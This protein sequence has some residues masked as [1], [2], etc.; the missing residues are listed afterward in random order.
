MILLDLHMPIMNGYEAAERIREI[1]KDIPIVAMTADV[2][3]GVREKCEQYGIYHYIS[4]P[5]NPERFIQIIWGILKNSG[6]LT[7]NLLH[8][9]QPQDLSK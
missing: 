6:T 7:R 4:K 2:I 8:W 5:F 3:V 1:S 9:T